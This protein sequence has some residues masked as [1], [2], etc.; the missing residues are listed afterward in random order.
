MTRVAAGLLLLAGRAAGAQNWLELVSPIL[1]ADERKAYAALA[2]GAREKFEHAFWA[3]KSIT[4]EEYFARVSYIDAGFGSG[5]PGSGANT[6]QGRVYL[7]MGAPNRITRAASSRYFVPLEIWNYTGPELRLIFYRPNSRGLYKLYSPEIDTICALLVPQAG[8]L[9]MFGPNDVITEAGIRTRLNSTPV[10]EEILSAAVSVSPGVK[11]AGNQET[12][13]R[14]ASPRAMLRKDVRPVVQSRFS[15][16]RPKLEVL[17]TSSPIGG[18]QADLAFDVQAR[19]EVRF[20]VLEGEA[21]LCTNVVHLKFER[22]AAVEYLHRLDL[23]PG[24][25]RVVISAD[26]T[27]YPFALEV[28]AQRSMGEIVRAAEAPRTEVRATPWEFEGRHLHPAGDGAFAVVALA[29]PG[30]VTWT[31]RR[32]YEIV[33]RQ[34]ESG[35]AT[36]VAALPLES[37]APGRY[38]L[39]TQSG[40]D[41]KGMEFEVEKGVAAGKTLLS[42]NANLTASARRVLLGREWLLRGRTDEARAELSRA[43]PLR[44]AQ[45][46]LARLEAAEG[47]LDA[48]R[49]RIRPL[50]AADR[51]DFDAL[52]VMAYIEAKLQDYEVA[53]DYYRRALAVHDSA[54]VRNALAALPR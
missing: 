11:G 35:G 28:P 46:E 33:W 54:T 26:G 30:E 43:L 40:R 18:V 48:A 17:L 27:A 31:I 34:K 12:L 32:G 3:D 44:E 38:R 53:A 2:P 8:L 21:T 29:Q 45:I 36:A 16:W 25:Y 22:V 1:S 9:G 15:V 5:R 4:E 19:S 51:A 50:L 37:L 20:E 6:D 42:H 14:V 52:S 7:A 49:V 47:R 23:L 24:S 13:A 41:S 39:E 10:E